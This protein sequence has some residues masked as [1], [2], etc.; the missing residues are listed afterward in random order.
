VKVNTL[1]PMHV[2][3]GAT[4]RSAWY[5]VEFAISSGYHITPTGDATRIL[6]R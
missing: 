2:Y 4:Y 1:G 6:L 3:F 5:A